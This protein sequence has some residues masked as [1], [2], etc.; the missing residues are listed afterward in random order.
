MFDPYI[1]DVKISAMYCHLFPVRSS[2]TA[3]QPYNNLIY[4]VL[5]P[6]PSFLTHY[7][8]MPMQYTENF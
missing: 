2:A 5:I 7:E 8:N 4:N 1:S 6:G 3:K